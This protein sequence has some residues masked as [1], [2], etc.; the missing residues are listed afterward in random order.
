MERYGTIS[1]DM[2]HCGD[3]Q[4]SIREILHTMEIYDTL[5]RYTAQYG[6]ERHTMEIHGTVFRDT[7]HYRDIEK[8]LERYGTLWKYTTHYGKI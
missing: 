2:A 8:T 5:W 6:D 4:K 7:A 1:R 3:K